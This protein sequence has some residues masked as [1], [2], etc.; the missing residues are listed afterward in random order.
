MLTSGFLAECIEVAQQAAERAASVWQDRR[1]LLFSRP[2]KRPLRFRDRCR[3]GFAADDPRN[4]WSP[5]SATRLYRRRR[6]IRQSPTRGGWPPTWI[7][8]PL[9]GTTNYLHDCPLYCVSIGLQVAGELVVGVILDPTRPELFRAAKGWRRRLGDER[10]STS[11]GREAGR[12]HV[13]HRLSRQHARPRP[14]VRLLAL[15][16]A[17]THALAAPAPRR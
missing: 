15:L 8:D 9:D 3:P 5:V 1:E 14:T 17:P 4:H 10:L 2:R 7:V 11:T 6:Q 12:C 16:R 13:G